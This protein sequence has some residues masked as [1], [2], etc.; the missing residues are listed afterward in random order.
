MMV[1][2]LLS[3]WDGISSGCEL[4]NFQVVGITCL[5]S[6]APTMQTKDK[7]KG[8]GTC[9]LRETKH[10]KL[11]GPATSDV[12]AMWPCGTSTE[13]CS[14]CTES[15]GE[16]S[17]KVPDLDLY[18]ISQQSRGNLIQ[19]QIVRVLCIQIYTHCASLDSTRACNWEV[20]FLNKEPSLPGFLFL[21]SSR[22]SV[23]SVFFVFRCGVPISNSTGPNPPIVV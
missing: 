21:L 7:G 11:H 20:Y 6:D 9:I 19:F 8:R 18:R 12:L 17:S 23:L 4:L 15:S 2:R 5:G 10:P 22:M 1:G 3:F 13:I 16:S 14:P